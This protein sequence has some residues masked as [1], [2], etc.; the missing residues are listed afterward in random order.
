MT[1]PIDLATGLT[2]LSPLFAAMGTQPRMGVGGEGGK[3]SKRDGGA[4]L[5][6]SLL[7]D[8]SLPLRYPRWAIGTLMQGEG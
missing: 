2:P 3:E 7:K 1:P 6:P 4:M 5:P 8:S